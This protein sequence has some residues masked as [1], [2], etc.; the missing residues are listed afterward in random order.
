MPASFVLSSG[1]ASWRRLRTPAL[2]LFLLTT[3][4]QPAQAERPTASQLFPKNTLAYLSAPDTRVLAERFQQTALGQMVQDPQMKPLVSQSYAA[5]VEAAKPLEERLGLNLTELLSLPQ[6]EV[7]IAV[8]PGSDGPPAVLALVDTAE[9]PRSIDK[10][11]E[12]GRATLI[13]SGASEQFEKVDDIELTI[14]RLPGEQSRQLIYFRKDNTV[15]I[16]TQLGSL[17]SLLATWTRKEGETLSQ[18]EHYAA[19]AKHTR[20]T[21]DEQPHLAWFVDPINLV[22][23]VGQ[24]NVNTQIGLALLPALGADGLHGVGGSITFAAGQ[25]DVINR[26]H[27]LLGTPRAGVLDLVALG[28]GNVIPERWVPGQTANYTTFYWDVEK[29]YYRISKLVDSFQGEGAFKRQVQRRIFDR[30]EIDIE[31]ELLP[32]LAGRFT[33][34]TMLEEP[35]SLNSNSPLIAAQLKDAKQFQATF[36]A[37][38]AKYSDFSVKKSFGGK[39]YVQFAPPE[40][41]EAP[42]DAPATGPRPCFC[43]VGDYLL[44]GRE[45]LLKQCIMTDADATKSLSEAL[46]FKLIANKAERQS[47]GSKPSLFNFNRPEEG[48]RFGYGLVAAQTTRDGLARRAEDNPFFKSLNQALTDNPLPPL[49]S[50]QKYVAPGG[51]VLIDDETGYHYTSFTL[52]RMDE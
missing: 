28:T 43:I 41:G 24:G 33:Y 31:K 52:R 48:L 34:L 23:N 44:I 46:D 32:A 42:A 15:A 7:A 4:L 11:L 35:I 6:G 26:I 39:V 49:S 18:N 10:L 50:L 36:D 29:T 5:V 47:G 19:I 22:R 51:A 45:S 1:P 8:V 3:S 12:R 27:V 25:F 37:I 40:L 9:D 14:F 2:A 30:T 13:E 38:A 16:G 20:G 21:K 17:K